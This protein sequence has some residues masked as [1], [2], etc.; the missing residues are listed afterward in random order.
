MTGFFLVPSS[1]AAKVFELAEHA[2]DDVTLLVQVP[3]TASLLLTVGLGRY[4][5][6]DVTLSE[7]VQQGIGVIPLVCQQRARAANVLHQGNRLGD[8]RRL[9]ACQNKTHGQAQC[10]GQMRVSCY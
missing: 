10:I 7:P 3:V 9:T 6:R 8:V 4:H 1:N 2:F 5:R